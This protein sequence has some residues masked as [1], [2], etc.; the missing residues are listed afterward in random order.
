MSRSWEQRTAREG[1]P[2]PRRRCSVAGSL[3]PAG[4]SWAAPPPLPGRLSLPTRCVNRTNGKSQPPHGAR[5]SSEFTMEMQCARFPESSR[6]PGSIRFCPR[7]SPLCPRERRHRHHAS[8]SAGLSRA[9]QG[10]RA[11]QAKGPVGTSTGATPVPTSPVTA[12]RSHC[13]V[14]RRRPLRPPRPGTHVRSVSPVRRF[15]GAL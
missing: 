13:T 9:A 3:F 7:D 10:S 2:K 1:W 5:T 14:A 12:V 15:P 8:P 6:S 11:L 4:P